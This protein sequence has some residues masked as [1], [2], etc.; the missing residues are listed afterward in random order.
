VWGRLREENV[1]EFGQLR[2]EPAAGRKAVSV[3][4]WLRRSARWYADKDA[5]IDGARR[6]T[7][8][9]FNER[10]NRHANG[11]AVL[12]IVKGDR[13]AVV[14]KNSVEAMEGFGAAAKAGFVHVPIN[15]RLSR[16]EVGDIL[17]HCGAR[18]FFVHREFAALL[19]LADECPDLEHVIVVDDGAA[20]SAYEKWLAAQSPAEPAADILAEDNFF[21]VY[22]SGTTGAA[23]GAYYQH[24]Q[25][26]AHAPVP[27]L[28]YDMRSDSRILLVYPH[29]SIASLNVVYVPA[30]MLGATVVLTD[31]RQFSAERWLD[32]VVREKVTHCH[33]VPTMLFRVLEHPRLREVDL[34]SL[35]TIGYGSAPMPQERIERL[36]EVFGSILM[37]AYGMTE[38]SSITTVFSK[39][40]HVEALR[41]NPERLRACGRPAFGSELRVVT[42]DGREVTPGKIGEIVFR[43]PLVMSGYWND[44]E[45]TAEAIHDGWLHSG[46]L[47]TVDAEGFIYIVDRKKDLIISGGANIA[48]SEVENV[49]Y[50]HEAVREAAVVGRPDDEWG[51]RVHAFVSLHDGKSLRSEELIAFCRDRLAHYKCPNSVEVLPDLPKNALGKILKSDLRAALWKGRTRA[52]N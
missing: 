11:L 12:G 33:L 2:G 29:N 22:T 31:V 39:Q 21:I 7:Y 3:P 1:N 27:V 13:V 38:V 17:R 30:W 43:G 23:K 19:D 24:R 16:R 51:E 10:V 25:P 48:S 14:L 44:P 18:A 35:Q 4:E 49:I 34:S 37:Q 15:F 52:V 42:E 26:A 46:D 41:N 28:G 6:F 47:A 50:W 5:V 8:R 9:Q 45:R 32:T 40:D 20:A 36:H